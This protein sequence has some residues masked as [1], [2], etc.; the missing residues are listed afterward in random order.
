MAHLFLAYVLLI[1]FSISSA[2]QTAPLQITQSKTSYGPD[3]PW[4]A[5]SIGLGTPAQTINL[6]PGGASY[7]SL[8]FSNTVCNSSSIQPCGLG[9][10]YNPGNSTGAQLDDVQFGSVDSRQ[11]DGGWTGGALLYQYSNASYNQDN[12]TLADGDAAPTTIQDADLYTMYDVSMVY[13]DGTHY[14]VQVG[15]LSLGNADANQTFAVSPDE[16]AINGTIAPSYLYAHNIIPSSSYGLHY[17]SAVFDLDLS[18]WLGGYDISRVVGP[19]AAQSYS[20]NTGNIFSIT[21]SDISIGVGTGASPFPYPSRSQILAENNDTLAD[22][23]SVII[24]PAAPY[25]NLPNSTC[26]AIAADLPVT[27]S[28]KYGLFLWDVSDPRYQ[29]IVGSPAYLSFIFATVS[30]AKLTIN[31]PFRLLNLTLEAPLSAVP[32]QYF[33]CQPPQD[34]GNQQYGLGR[35]F[36]QAAFIAVHWE[37]DSGQW[38]LAQA[39]GP[40][41]SKNPDQVPITNS[42]ITASQVS[43]VDTWEDHW[44]PINSA[45][46]SPVAVSHHGLASG[47]IAGIVVGVVVAVLI[48]LVTVFLVYRRRRSKNTTLSAEHILQQDNK[49]EDKGY[50]WGEPALDSKAKDEPS[51]MHH[52]PI[53]MP[54]VELGGSEQYEM[55]PV[56]SPVESGGEAIQDASMNSRLS[57]AT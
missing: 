52:D 31:V 36:L 25:L 19:V 8:I 7:G 56:S 32:I 28:N 53:A 55:S 46:P 48:S 38:Y 23:L 54:I 47:A 49:G 5:V 51:E 10:L 50:I 12:M 37:S 21:L 57:A 43:W 11:T 34:P 14:P 22:G 35:A 16:P 40:R 13:P 39:P 6:F 33:P 24:N 20:V 26:A 1:C 45:A 3:G 41:V 9:G 15:L 2:Y 27:Y 18:L 17:G 4:H 30:P 42:T 44:T 29:Q